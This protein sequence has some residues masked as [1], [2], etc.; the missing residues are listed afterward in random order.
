MARKQVSLQTRVLFGLGSVADGVKNN[1]FTFFLLFY[2]TQV[3]GL[4][5]TLAGAVILIALVFDAVSDPLI[6]SLSD[7]FASPWGRRHPFMYGA[8]LP[9]TLCFL[10]LFHPPDGL[11]QAGLFVWMLCFAIGVRVS[12]TFYSIPSTALIAEMTDNYDER[13][14]IVSFR[15]LSGWIGGLTA[16]QLAYLVFMVPSAEYPDGRLNPGAYSDYAM[17]GGAMIF[18]AILICSLATHRLIPTLHQPAPVPFSVARFQRELRQVFSNRAYVVLVIGILFAATAS[19]FTDTTNLY[20]NTYFWEFSTTELSY[21][22][23]GAAV[24]TLLAFALTPM[25]SRLTDKRTMGI[26]CMAVIVFI[27]PLPV[28]LRLLELMPP[29]GD[30][31]LL[32]I[33]V[34]WTALIV[35]VAVAVMMLVGSMIAD[36]IDQNEL[37]TGQRQEGM[38]NAAY[39]LISKATS[40]LGGFVAGVAIDVIDFPTGVAAGE[41]DADTVYALGLAVGP[42]IFL[43]WLGTLL[44][45]TRYPLQRAEHQRI[46]EAL[47]RRREDLRAAESTLPEPP[48]PPA[49]RLG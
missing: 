41:V 35:F 46:I 36:I 12:M 1:A 22:I 26:G 29:N 27:G 23:W 28:A 15:V 39:A 40:G 44:M 13:T 10:A 38:F 2:Y 47:K 43:F 11:G 31:L 19:G 34:A 24:G 17:T 8:A 21:T 30:P 9:M 33:I 45:F 4:S 5:G 20:V 18:A 16:L 32:Q 37:R 14:S 7:N 6:G 49:R 42:G 3:L 48:T 25:L